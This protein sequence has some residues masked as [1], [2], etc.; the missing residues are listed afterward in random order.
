MKSK[1]NTPW[2]LR[3]NSLKL[4]L[5]RSEGKDTG[6]PFATIKVI[7]CIGKERRI[8][9]INRRDTALATRNGTFSECNICNLRA[10]STNKIKI[11][12]Y[13]FFMPDKLG[14]FNWF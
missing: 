9:G 5:I 8:L 2:A 6:E 7:S 3:N 13:F 10:Q 1:I 11:S 14:K 4:S 12:L